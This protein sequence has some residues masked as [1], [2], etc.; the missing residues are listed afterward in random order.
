MTI[1]SL[2]EMIGV[3]LRANHPVFVCYA[4]TG[5]KMTLLTELVLW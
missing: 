3:L 5:M 4:S 1:R 2:E